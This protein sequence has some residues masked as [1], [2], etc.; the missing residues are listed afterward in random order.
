LAAQNFSF[1]A[2]VWRVP[3]W[4]VYRSSVSGKEFARMLG[5]SAWLGGRAGHTLA[6][7]VGRTPLLLCAVCFL[8]AAAL[9]ENERA[10]R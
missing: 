3:Q 10:Q 7:V 2:A 6:E 5:R 9:L 1:G 8:G 4:R